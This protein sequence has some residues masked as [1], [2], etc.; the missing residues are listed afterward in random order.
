MKPLRINWPL[1]GISF[2]SF[3]AWTFLVALVSL[4]F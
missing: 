2:L 4:V 1:L 3:L